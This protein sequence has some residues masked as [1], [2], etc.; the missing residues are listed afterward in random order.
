[1]L[2]RI[3]RKRD[4]FFFLTSEITNRLNIQEIERKLKN[5]KT[6]IKIG[7]VVHEL[8]QTETC[9]EIESEKRHLYKKNILGVHYN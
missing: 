9:R 4:F 1:M 8:L 6:F 7:L 5:V 3:I 2:R